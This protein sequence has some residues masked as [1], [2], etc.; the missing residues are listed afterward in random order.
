[1]GTVASAIVLAFTY[2]SLHV[3]PHGDPTPWMNF[4][5]AMG[6]STIHSTADF[7]ANGI[8]D[9]EDAEILLSNLGKQEARWE[10]G[11]VNGDRQVDLQD[12]K[13]A[14]STLRAQGAFSHP[15]VS[16]V[17]LEYFYAHESPAA[18][19]YV[20]RYEGELA[21]AGRTE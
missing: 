9:L 2:P 7:D 8:S 15:Q 4:K 18:Q 3:A 13:R 1:L 20:Q 5:G 16:M 12:W 21:T 10:D 19:A 6:L 11:D 17:L 14:E